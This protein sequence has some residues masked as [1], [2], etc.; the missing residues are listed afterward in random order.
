MR[1]HPRRLLVAGDPMHA[2]GDLLPA[3][4]RKARQV[5]PAQ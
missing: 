3:L 5:Q 2:A 1:D 4:G